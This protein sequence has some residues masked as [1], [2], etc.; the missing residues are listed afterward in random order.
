MLE[1][2][3]ISHLISWTATN[4]SFV[5]TPGEEFS[6]VLS[7]YFKHTNVSSFV[8][9]LNMY[10]FHKVNDTFHGS[11]PSNISKGENGSSTEGASQWEFKHGGGSFK[12]GDVESLRAI[13][14]RASRQN[15]ANR[16]NS[17]LKSVSLSVPSTPPD[18]AM[19]TNLANISSSAAGGTFLLSPT[20]TM[21]H[22]A[23]PNVQ[24]HHARSEAAFQNMRQADLESRLGN[25]EHFLYYYQDWSVRAQQKQKIVSDIV[26]KSQSDIVL[27]MEYIYDQNRQLHPDSA[28]EE[29]TT[30]NHIKVSQLVDEFQHRSLI[31]SQ[32][33]FDT[34]PPPFQPGIS[35]HVATPYGTPT[36]NPFP[37]YYP[38]SYQQQQLQHHLQQQAQ[39]HQQRP[40]LFSH[41]GH[42]Y[43]RQDQGSG[44]ERQASVLYD[45]LTVPSSNP[46]SSPGAASEDKAI[47][48][49]APVDGMPNAG[50]RPVRNNSAPN[51]T[52]ASP[53]KGYN[54]LITPQSPTSQPPVGNSG[55]STPTDTYFQPGYNHYHAYPVSTTA[56]LSIPFAVP[57]DAQSTG[58]SSG[59]QNPNSHHLAAPYRDQRSGS[60]PMVSFPHKQRSKFGSAV[61]GHINPVVSSSRAESSPTAA[62]FQ[63][64]DIPFRRHTSG[65]VLT[66][67]L[68]A[69]YNPPPVESSPVDSSPGFSATSSTYL[70]STSA[71]SESSALLPPI[72]PSNA[73]I[74]PKIR[75]SSVKSLLNP[76]SS[77]TMEEASGEPSLKRIKASAD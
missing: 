11:N 36:S 77:S 58:S 69:P 8:R 43:S 30:R 39:G 76:S 49:S 25:I 19:P 4:D 74:S 24:Q 13:K 59:G 41:Y 32:L 5:L 75:H 40:A 22:Q 71:T 52:S 70:P 20:N 45:P 15:T 7:Q 48:T 47:P 37:N 28:K 46:P 53:L 9:Q 33:D 55:A 17:S 21:G 14:R 44:R 10:G 35:T 18:F 12:R 1:D 31:L 42:L 61:A 57:S 68:S 16:D 72:Q 38:P 66:S 56:G 63:R 6:K 54:P 26:R 62:L 29:E 64:H 50:P 65:D 51:L 73:N 23:T 3:S 2:S 34:P 60:F 27:L 67:A